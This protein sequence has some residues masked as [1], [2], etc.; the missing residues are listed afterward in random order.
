M[1]DITLETTS[2]EPSEE[3]E[4]AIQQL[5]AKIDQSFAEMRRD[6]EEIALLKRDSLML[7]AETQVLLKSI[8]GMMTHAG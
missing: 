8:K 4:S 6:A 5:F 7:Q 2:G 1:S 3:M